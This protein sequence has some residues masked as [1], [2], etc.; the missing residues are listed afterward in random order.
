MPVL[1][2]IHVDEVDHDDAAQIAQA[3]LTHD[4]RNRI[5][6]RLENGVLKRAVLPT[7][8]PVLMSIAT[9]ASVWLITMDP[10]DFSHTFDFSALVI[11]S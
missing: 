2:L 3:N 11:S 9:S 10:P 6:V 7:Y 4:L 5:E 8:L 1:A